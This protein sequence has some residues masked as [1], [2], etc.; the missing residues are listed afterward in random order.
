MLGRGIAD[1]EGIEGPPGAVDGLGLLD[2]TTVLTGGKRLAAV[3]GRFAGAP[4][5]GY[6]MHLGRTTGPDTS[7][8]LLTLDDGRPDGAVSRD[9]RVGG[10]YVHGLF[11]GDAARAAWLASLG[12]RAAPRSHDAEL[13]AALDALAAHLET[14]IDIDRLLSLAR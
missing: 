14:H 5:S 4:F 10:T 3:Q 7:A 1:P 6:E 9:G 2:I 12:A 11:L 8:P 13:E